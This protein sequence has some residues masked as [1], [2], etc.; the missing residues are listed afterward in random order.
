MTFPAAPQAPMIAPA[1]EGPRGIGGW[2]ILPIIGF[3]GT[4]LLTGWNLAEVLRSWDGVVAIFT[5]ESMAAARFPMAMSFLFGALVIASAAVSLYLLFAKKRAVVT[6]ATVHYLILAAAGLVLAS[7]S[8]LAR[9]RLLSS[10]PLRSA[11][12][13]F[14]RGQLVRSVAHVRSGGARSDPP[15]PTPPQVPEMVDPARSGRHDGSLRRDRHRR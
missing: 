5:T 10:Q 7:R 6:A 15:G 11:R 9:R 13:R 3:I 1:D 2:L 8:R 4:M 12:R 14:R